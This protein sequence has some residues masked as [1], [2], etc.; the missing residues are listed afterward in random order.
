MGKDLRNSIIPPHQKHIYHYVIDRNGNWFCEGNP[1]LDRDLLKILSSSLFEKDGRYY[2]RCEGEIHPVE[3]EDAPL[4][5]KYVHISRNVEGEIEKIEIE[6]IDGRKEIL[7]PETLWLEGESG[8]YCLA[9][10]K[11]LR[12]KFGKIAYYEL[13]NNISWQEENHSYCLEVNGRTYNIPI[14]N[15]Q[16]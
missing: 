11:N 16:F 15:P 13:A 4:W 1:V 12:T 14:R 3:V 2:I 7:R 8:L 10:R 6:L 9:T 5:V